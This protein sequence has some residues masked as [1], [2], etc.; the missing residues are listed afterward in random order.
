MYKFQFAVPRTSFTQFILRL[1]NAENII[2]KK[3]KKFIHKKSLGI[4]PIE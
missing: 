2:E 3:E 4:V 1:Q